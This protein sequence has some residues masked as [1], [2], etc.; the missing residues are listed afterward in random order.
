MRRADHGGG[1]VSLSHELLGQVSVCTKYPPDKVTV[2]RGS[3]HVPGVQAE[4]ELSHLGGT[5]GCVHRQ[6]HHDIGTKGTYHFTTSVLTSFFFSW[7][8]LGVFCVFF[9]GWGGGGGVVSS[10]RASVCLR[11]R[12]LL[13]V[14]RPIYIYI[15][16]KS[17][18]VVLCQFVDYSNSSTDSDSP[19]GN[20]ITQVSHM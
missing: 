16:A 13:V 4:G 18:S 12:A 1:G 8:F 19:V 5:V 14:G 6:V 20:I 11:V 15:R 2:L 10:E 7:V 17:H 3:V 9:L